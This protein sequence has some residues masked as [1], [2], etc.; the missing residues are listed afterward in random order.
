MANLQ[1]RGRP[2]CF[3]DRLIRPCIV[4]REALRF[5]GQEELIYE[6]ELS[7]RTPGGYFL[8]I[9]SFRRHKNCLGPRVPSAA[10]TSC[11]TQREF[12]WAV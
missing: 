2:S 10:E 1:L 4:R 5:D 11:S 12:E 7:S 6:T 3:H 8:R 9:P